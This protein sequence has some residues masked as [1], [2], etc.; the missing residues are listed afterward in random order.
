VARPNKKGMSYY[1]T[2]ID[3]LRDDKIVW[4]RS[5][6]KPAAVLM[7]QSL[8]GRMYQAEGPIE[9]TNF[10]LFGVS[11]ECGLTGEDLDLAMQGALAVKLI[12]FD[13]QANTL[14][15]NGVAERLKLVTKERDRMR[16]RR[17]NPEQLPNKPE[18]TKNKVEQTANSVSLSFSNLDL[19]LV[20]D[21]E[22][23]E[24]KK[25]EL[26]PLVFLTL[27]QSARFQAEFG[28]PE[29]NYWLDRL[30]E[31]AGKNSAKWRKQYQDH[32]LVMRSWRNRKLEEG[33]TWNPGDKRYDKQ[34]KQFT[35]AKERSD[36]REMQMLQQVST[37]GQTAVG[38]V[39]E[40][41]LQKA[42]SAVKAIEVKS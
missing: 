12:T 7:V 37:T 41:E 17:T 4:L 34:G 27:D 33:Y 29:L 2:D 22:K 19:D 13:S 36:I 6:Y 14:F 16:E 28:E 8:W 42:T 25:L 40:R 24:P 23:G 5:E 26:R 11:Q 20:L 30:A 15:S 31:F 32:N 21:Q 38:A 35:S 18:Q 39:I 10:M 9:K 3:F 1:P